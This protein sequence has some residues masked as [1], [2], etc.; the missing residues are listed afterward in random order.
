M[1]STKTDMHSSLNE[2]KNC[3]KTG[4]PPD[5]AK[6][7]ESCERCQ[8]IFNG[9]ENL[10]VISDSNNSN[11]TE[12]IQQSKDRVLQQLHKHRKKRKPTILKFA[13]SI[14]IIAGLSWVISQQSDNDDLK[15]VDNEIAAIYKSPPVLRNNQADDWSQF[16]LLY[17]AEKYEEAFDLLVTL[18]TS[19]GQSEFYKGLCKMYQ[20]KPNFDEAIIFLNNEL[21][22]KS[23]YSQQASYFKALCYLK[24]ED[25]QSAK[26]LLVE[27]QQVPNHYK[28]EEVILH[29][30]DL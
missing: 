17:V 12:T 2:I 3:I 29:L 18:E 6:H 11:T 16:S 23:R 10:D 9:L 28:L 25:I 14:L 20:A 4:G 7:I 13:A 30:E 19:S 1:N 21:V 15:L 26:K 5:V 22:Q 8:T 27:M 24:I